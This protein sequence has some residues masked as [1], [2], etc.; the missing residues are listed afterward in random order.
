M[1]YESSRFV[2]VYSMNFEDRVNIN[3]YYYLWRLRRKLVSS[4]PMISK[5]KAFIFIHNFKT[6]GTS[7]E[8]KLGHFNTLEADVQDHRTLRDIERLTER[9]FYFRKGLYALKIGKPNSAY[10]FL[11][12][13]AFPE[14]TKAEYE[15]FYKFTFV[16]NTW[17]RLYSWYAN[18]MKDER[19]RRKF[20]ITDEGLSYEDFLLTKVNHQ[21]FSQLHFITD[22][23]GAVPMDFIGRFET[24]QQ[25]FDTVCEHLNISDSTLPKLLV[26]KYG[27]YTENYTDVTK[28]LVYSLYKDEIDYFNFEFGD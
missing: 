18:I 5:E 2:F 9:S 8:K 26:R 7:I 10:R 15:S 3:F 14:L 20:N 1:D 23:K 6:G 12:T 22:S 13:A 27:H 11:K 16:R 19:M 25:D 21:T 24:L 17:A 28:D 4:R